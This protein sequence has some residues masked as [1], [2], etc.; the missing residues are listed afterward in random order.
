LGE[1][2]PEQRSW[3]RRFVDRECS[4]GGSWELLRLA[5]PLVL[6]SSFFT[7]QI[8]A[9]RLM[10]SQQNS[11]VVGAAMLAG[12]N[13]WTPLAL[14]Y[15]TAMYTSTFVAQYV[16]AGRKERVGAAVWQGIYFSVFAGLG[17]LLVIP[18][19]RPYVNLIGDSPELREPMVQYLFCLCFATLPFLLVQTTNA[20]FSGRGDTWRVLLTDSTGCITAVVFCY[21]LINGHWG[22]Q[23]M[24]IVGAGW[25]IVIGNWTAVTVGF[26]MLMLPRFR[27]EFN[28]LGAWRFE[29]A[30]FARMM[31][32]G[33]PN[34][35]Q[36]CL[37][38]LAFNIFLILIGR[39]GMTP[40]S[41]TSIAFT[42][43]AA[44]LVPM[45]GL[46]QAVS[47]LVGQ[48]LGE[49]RPAIAQRSAIR[50][51]GWCLLYTGCA[52]LVF[53]A[54]PEVL[55]RQFADSDAERWEKVGPLIPMLLKFVALYCM[56][57]S[58]SL[59]LSS[60]LRGA[61][62]TRFVSAVTLVFSWLIMV[63]PTLLVWRRGLTPVWTF[64]TA[65][66]TFLSF[67]FVWR[68]WQ[69]KWKSMRVI[70]AAPKSEPEVAPLSV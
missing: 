45:L 56:F 24:G 40:L 36:Y 59:I 19:L 54:L 25:A 42:I 27:R 12:V 6:S 28:T 64:A 58:V 18:L 23:A 63:V 2:I 49:D 47:V 4:P 17:F 29:P 44:A 31:R 13:Y 60:A 65:Y 51:V 52:A 1:P 14:L 68:F 37:E 26:T 34:G 61:G 70:E 5:F 9:D 8:T 39:M 22:F 16:G 30:L 57:E 38:A 10:L 46:G 53:V 55:A 15:F 67:V 48:R 43:N 11:E 7:I 69:G 33:M 20:F 32:Y 62:D 50:G 41:A 35:L 66:V 21:A 3:L